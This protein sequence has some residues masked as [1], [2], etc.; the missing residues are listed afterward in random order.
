MC[1]MYLV[2]LQ[3]CT[4]KMQLDVEVSPPVKWITDLQLAES[5]DFQFYLADRQT[6]GWMDGRTAKNKLLEIS[7][8][9]PF[10]HWSIGQIGSLH[11]V[12]DAVHQDT[13]RTSSNVLNLMLSHTNLSYPLTLGMSK[14]MTMTI[15]CWFAWK[16]LGLGYLGQ[17]ISQPI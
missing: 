5:Q 14:C 7:H 15:N 6:D 13:S 1:F 4:K 16:Q 17:K 9:H 12:V 11:I 10:G 3:T 8:H 2:A